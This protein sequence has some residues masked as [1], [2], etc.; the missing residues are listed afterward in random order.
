MFD[1]EQLHLTK[2]KQVV[3]VV[4]FFKMG[5]ISAGKVWEGKGRRGGS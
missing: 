5:S 4:K 3:G 2:P 1:E